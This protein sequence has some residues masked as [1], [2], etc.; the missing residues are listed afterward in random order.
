ML[1][2]SANEKMYSCRLVVT[3]KLGLYVHA[4][5]TKVTDMTLQLV[6]DI[7]HGSERTGLAQ[8]RTEEVVASSRVDVEVNGTFRRLKL[9]YSLL[10]WGAGTST[11]WHK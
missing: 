6:T 1:V 8:Q 11:S 4:C 5:T 2:A 9:R 7:E 3:H 10:K